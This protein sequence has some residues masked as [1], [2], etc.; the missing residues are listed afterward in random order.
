[1]EQLH[2]LDSI[3]V[4]GEIPNVPLHIGALF[5]YHSK[6][7]F[8]FEALN[9]LLE[10]QIREHLPILQCRL[11]T[12]PWSVDKPYWVKDPNFC[13]AAHVQH[14]ALPEPA[15]WDALHQVAERFHAEPLNQQRPLW[16]ALVIEGLDHCEDIPKGSVALI[17]KIHHA[18]ADGKT[19]M[20][21]F[22]ALHSLLPEPGASLL[23]ENMDWQSP[24]FSPPGMI[25]KYSRAWWHAVSAPGRVM[26]DMVQAVPGL[27]PSGS[28][29]APG[30]AG[31]ALAPTRFNAMPGA[32]RLLGH[33]RMPMAQLKQLE[34]ACNVTIND[35]A[36]CVVAG[37]LRIY[38]DDHG[39]LPDEDLIACMPI[40]TRHENDN[41]S[42]GNQVGFANLGLHTDI[43]DSLARLEA[44]HQA[45]HQVKNESKR[46]KSGSLVSLLDHLNPGLLVWAGQK[47]VDSGMLEKIRPLNNTVVTNVPGLDQTC[48][49]NGAR[50]VDYLG[51]GLLAPTVSLFHVVSS[52][53][54]HVNITFISCRSA[55]DD[56]QHYVAALQTAW[57]Q[58]LDAA[59]C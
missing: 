59:D 34:T 52:V 53:E 7:D 14:F 46:K 35:I 31:T 6:Q 33:L 56:P 48:Y 41:S 24:D 54:T 18:L 8:D 39:E 11:E 38:L 17:V 50:L 55:M 5:I 37:G 10:R 58:L 51:L 19:A 30:G 26:M 20:R 21:L 16:Q 15:N 47:M 22:A 4:L 40:N 42:F 27:L 57:Q 3:M 2:G 9:T 43:D 29:S 28:R 49:L 32:D 13:F 12:L 36:L 23:A 44:I 1:M 45:T 25:S